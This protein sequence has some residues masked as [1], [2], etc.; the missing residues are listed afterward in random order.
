MISEKDF[1]E[2]YT[3]FWQVA[4]PTSERLIREANRLGYGRFAPPLKTASRPE[5][6]GIIAEIA[7]E[8]LRESYSP[9]KIK[10]VSPDQIAIIAKAAYENVRRLAQVS[11]ARL[12][13]PNSREISEAQQLAK[14]MEKF[15]FEKELAIELVFNPRFAGCGVIDDCYGDLLANNTLYEIKTGDRPYRSVDLRQVL[16]YAALNYASGTYPITRIALL[17][18][19]LGTYL[20]FE[21]DILSDQLSGKAPA[22]LFGDIV[23]FVSS[24]NI[25]L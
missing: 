18:P 17:N 25:S 10:P 14:R 13:S 3:S 15:F 23:H 8:I 6:H 21:L 9:L 19:R 2:K 24:D 7:F 11:P 16:V 22:E 12:P 20:R 1:A 4:V 5:S